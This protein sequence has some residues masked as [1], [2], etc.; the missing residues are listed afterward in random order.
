MNKEDIV[1]FYIEDMEARE[2]GLFRIINSLIIERDKAV[3]S[4]E[5]WRN[6]SVD[7]MELYKGTAEYSLNEKQGII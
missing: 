2:K 1:Y 4:K 6:V 5:M 7:W 3:S